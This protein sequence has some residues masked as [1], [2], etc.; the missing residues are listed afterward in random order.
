[1]AFVDPSG[2]SSDAM[3]LGI[4]HREGET[5][6]LD[7]LREYR[8]PFSPESVCADYAS[9]IK[10]YRCSQIFGDR[11]EGE[12]VVEGFRKYGVHYEECE[13]TRSELYLN[14]LPL[15]NSGGVALVD[16]ERM[17][18]QFVSLERKTSSVRDRVDHPLF[19]NLTG[20]QKSGGVDAW[21]W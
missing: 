19:V 9:T 4:A 16:H 21:L 10:K 20:E 3:T 7:L 5:I 11:Y 2:G 18:L 13:Q 1:V 14:I 12:W 15:I 6:V 17:M 8:P